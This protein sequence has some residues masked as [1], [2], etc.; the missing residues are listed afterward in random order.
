MCEKAC[1]ITASSGCWINAWVLTHW[2]CRDVVVNMVIG[3]CK[4]MD[5]LNIFINLIFFDLQQALMLSYQV[6]RSVVCEKKT[7]GQFRGSNHSVVSS[8]ILRC[9]WKG[10]STCGSYV[11]RQFDDESPFRMIELMHSYLH[12]SFSVHRCCQDESENIW[13]MTMDN[14]ISN[15]AYRINHADVGKD[16]SHQSNKRGR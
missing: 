13:S 15:S 10:V 9:C 3:G 14:V 2:F 4:L 6:Q 12:P 7:Q 16:G 5:V 11:I 1:H 8:Y